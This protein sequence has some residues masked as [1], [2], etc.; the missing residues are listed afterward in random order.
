[1]DAGTIRSSFSL[2][3][4]RLTC[5][6]IGDSFVVQSRW[7]RFHKTPDIHEALV[8]FEGL[9][10]EELP[11]RDHTK[12]LVREARRNK[13]SQFTSLAAWERRVIECAR[14]R[15]EG[16]VPV[17]CGRKSAVELW[18]PQASALTCS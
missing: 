14:R 13:R 8:V 4:V 9:C 6:R 12:R 5:D 17:I 1:M 7:Q 3:G 2:E 18:R 16:L 11:G 15:A 10:L